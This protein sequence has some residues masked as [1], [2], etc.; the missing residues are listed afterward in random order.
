MGETFFSDS[1]YQSRQRIILESKSHQAV[2][3]TYHYDCVGLQGEPLFTDAIYLGNK[4]ASHVFIVV[5]GTHG[6]EGHAGSACQLFT[7][8]YFKKI[9]EMN[10]NVGILLVHA[11]NPWGYAHNRRTTNT[12]VDLNRNF[13]NFKQPLPLN[14]EYGKLHRQL[15]ECNWFSLK[16]R[17]IDI[18]LF[19]KVITGKKYE[20]QQALTSGQYNHPKGLFYGGNCI[21]NSRHVWEQILL[22]FDLNNKHSLCLLD[23]HTGLGKRHVGELISERSKNDLWFN[24]I[25]VFFKSQ[26]KSTLSGSSVSAKVSGTLCGAFDDPSKNRIAL[27]LEFGTQNPLRVLKA[28][29]LEQ[30]IHNYADQIT[31]QNKKNYVLNLMKNAFCPD[32][33]YWQN[34]VI[35]RYK[36]VLELYIDGLSQ[37]VEK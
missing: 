31:Y 3:K 18:Q 5:S 36:E 34:N 29:R 27:V 23:I 11:I 25:S 13:I 1:Y 22:D 4:N 9:Q 15:V 26:I 28:L 19:I 10:A 33:F 32:S 20:V 8:H 21:V 17:V 12:G 30:W 24:K 14:L 7:M 16:R 2:V 37:D 35:S 6:V